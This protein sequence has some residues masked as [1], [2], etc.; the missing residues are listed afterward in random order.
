MDKSLHVGVLA[1]VYM[2]FEECKIRQQRNTLQHSLD[3]T[4][5]LICQSDA[6]GLL[7]AT[8]HFLVQVMKV[9]SST[10]TTVNFLCCYPLTNQ[11]KILSL[12]YLE[13]VALSKAIDTGARLLQSLDEIGLKVHA[14]NVYF[15]CDSKTSIQWASTPPS[16]LEKRV[17]HVVS[18]ICLTLMALDKSP[19]E[20]L[21]HDQTKQPLAAD[22]L[23]KIDLSLPFLEI[24]KYLR[25]GWKRATE[26]M[27][28]DPKEWSHLSRLSESGQKQKD[29]FSYY[30]VTLRQLVESGEEEGG[31]ILGNIDTKTRKNGNEG[32]GGLTKNITHEPIWQIIEVTHFWQ[33]LIFKECNKKGSSYI[34]YL[35]LRNISVGGGGGSSPFLTTSI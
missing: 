12:P 28:R 24:S 11:N 1:A 29:T 27:W 26:W 13:L 22:Y 30:D 21:F 5:V 31:S 16:L 19:T 20:I 9:G 18:K 33:F 4:L 23:T 7:H 15:C 14:K 6:G 34:T 8:A 32:K 25:D 17:S 3:C 2:Y 10:S 35:L